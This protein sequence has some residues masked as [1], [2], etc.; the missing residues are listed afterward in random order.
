ME[1]LSAKDEVLTLGD[2]NYGMIAHGN[3]MGINTAIHDVIDAYA[4]ATVLS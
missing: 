2:I 3:D 4:I 1:H